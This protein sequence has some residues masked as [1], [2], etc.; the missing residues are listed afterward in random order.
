[1]IQQ[2]I[3]Y[4]FELDHN[5]KVLGIPVSISATKI[6]KYQLIALSFSILICFLMLILVN[7]VYYPNDE[8]I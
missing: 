3:D 2:E 5:Y 8:A 6:G 1:M 4:N 7:V